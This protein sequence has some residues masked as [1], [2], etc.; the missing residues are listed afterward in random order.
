[1][2]DTPQ[3]GK[4]PI[5]KIRLPRAQTQPPEMDGNMRSWGRGG[6]PP[7]A[8]RAAARSAEMEAEAG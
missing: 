2:A 6:Q 7:G 1:M 3:D 8:A 4:Q 5:V